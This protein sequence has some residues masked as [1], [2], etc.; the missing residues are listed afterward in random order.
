[1]KDISTIDYAIL[2]RP[3]V[4]MFLFHPR[5]EPTVS[6][7]QTAE[8]ETRMAGQKDILI[9]VQ[10]EIAVGARFHMAE[11]SGGNLLF[12]HGNGEIVADYDELGAVY[13][14]MGINL[15][16]V[17]YRGYGRSGG[18]PTVTAMMRDC[19]SIF[20]FVR[21]WLQKNNYT[22]PILLMGRSL[23]S[24]SVLELAAAYK[25]LIDGLIVESGFAYAGPLLTLLGIDF[26]ALGF[27]EEKGFRNVDKIKNFDKPTLIIHAEFD[28]IIPYSDGQTLH[29]ACPSGDKKLLKIPGA[30]HNDIFMRGLQE[31][32]AAVKN[33]VATAK[34]NK[35]VSVL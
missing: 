1:M 3:E 30:N 18:K 8:P 29:D 33:I 32:L 10:A 6:P 21:K 17:D 7:F 16:A 5:P 13:N 22:G 24:A 25:N 2:D 20:H 4:L 11:K 34:K 9:P 19:H 14:Q 15:L 27:K 31:Y 26:A 28:H 35:P 12:F 23:G